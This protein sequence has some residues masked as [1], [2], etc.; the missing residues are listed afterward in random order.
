MEGSQS[1]RD[2]I[3]GGQS[4]EHRIKSVEA[5]AIIFVVRTVE[6][7]MFEPLATEDV[8]KLESGS[9]EQPEGEGENEGGGRMEGKIAVE[10]GGEEIQGP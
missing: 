6:Q 4:D 7:K 10:E 3:N 1:D 2:Q 5:A 8:N 9:G